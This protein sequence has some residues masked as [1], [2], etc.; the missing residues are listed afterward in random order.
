M[1]PW[2]VQGCMPWIDLGDQSTG[3][4]KTPIWRSC[5]AV[6]SLRVWYL[7]TNRISTHKGLQYQWMHDRSH[8]SIHVDHVL[9][10]PGR[11]RLILNCKQKTFSLAFQANRHHPGKIEEKG[12]W[13]LVRRTAHKSDEVVSRKAHFQM[14]CFTWLTSIGV[15]SSR[16]QPSSNQSH[17]CR[18]DGCKNCWGSVLWGPFWYPFSLLSEK[19]RSSKQECNRLTT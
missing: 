3:V 1:T 14:K 18:G 15:P 4:A 16:T 12:W 17:P 10:V 5:H 6:M 7:R 2:H 9:S 11:K 8:I 19:R 13:C